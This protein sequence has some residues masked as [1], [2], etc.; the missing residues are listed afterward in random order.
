[1]A[2]VAG[3]PGSKDIR[4]LCVA[5]D[6]L[7]LGSRGQWFRS[8]RRDQ[9]CKPATSL[10]EQDKYQQAGIH[11]RESGRGCVYSIASCFPHIQKGSKI[12][13]QENRAGYRKG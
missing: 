5:T 11:L 8:Y 2:V 13:S 4:V 3:L 9:P 1:M 6:V 12:I 7:L 10:P